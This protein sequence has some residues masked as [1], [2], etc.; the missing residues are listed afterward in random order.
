MRVGGGGSRAEEG[1]IVDD[2]HSCRGRW[3]ETAEKFLWRNAKGR[4]SFACPLIKAIAM[5]IWN[6]EARLIDF[7]PIF[8]RKLSNMGY[9][10]LQTSIWNLNGNLIFSMRLEKVCN[11]PILSTSTKP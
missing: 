6:C 4:E 9:F 5:R 11:V 8:G 2:F 3:M 10:L 1:E 7:I